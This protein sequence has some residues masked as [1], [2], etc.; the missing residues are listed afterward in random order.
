[1]TKE[2][3]KAQPHGLPRFRQPS[4][5]LEKEEGYYIYMDLPGVGKDDLVIDLKEN[6]MVVSGKTRYATRPEEK[7]I[8]VE[9]GNCEYRR[10]FTLSEAVDREKIKANLKNGVL[11]VHMPK[12]EKATPKR[13]DIQAG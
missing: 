3:T 10:T 11:E 4:D 2:M 1:M 8:E 7:Y 9:F 5:I 13:I 12:A 6:E